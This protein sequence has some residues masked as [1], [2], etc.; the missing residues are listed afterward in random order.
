MTDTGI[1]LEITMGLSVVG[2]TIR[3]DFKVQNGDVW[4]ID[5][6]RKSIE[7]NTPIMGVFGIIST[8]ENRL[9]VSLSPLE[10]QDKDR[11][12]G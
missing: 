3:S 9:S 4:L 10:F 12:I 7:N 5:K 1:V 8:S 11:V 2:L 6:N